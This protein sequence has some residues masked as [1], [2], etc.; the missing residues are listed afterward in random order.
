MFTASEQFVTIV[1][2]YENNVD[3]TLLGIILLHKKH[4]TLW[5]NLPFFSN[6]VVIL[7]SCLKCLIPFPRIWNVRLLK[8]GVPSQCKSLSTDLSLYTKWSTHSSKIFKSR[9]TNPSTYKFPQILMSSANI[10]TYSFFNYSKK[11][12]KISFNFDGII[13]NTLLSVSSRKRLTIWNISTVCSSCAFM[14]TTIL[15]HVLW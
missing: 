8:T 10:I 13:S 5:F 15:K 12:L 6:L 2:A 3:L 4:L 7:S 1:K 9:H 11:D 14:S